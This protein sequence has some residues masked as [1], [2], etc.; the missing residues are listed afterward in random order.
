MIKGLQIIESGFLSFGFYSLI[1]NVVKNHSV[2]KIIYFLYHA[3]WRMLNFVFKMAS[4]DY[5]NPIY[6]VLRKID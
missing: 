4:D 5:Q 3:L 6:L 1:L 2:E